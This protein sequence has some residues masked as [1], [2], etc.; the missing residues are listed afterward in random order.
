MAD[1]KEILIPVRI[2]S[3][4]FRDFAVFDAFERRG[5]LRRIA[6][7][8]GLLTLCA[9]ACLAL[10]AAMNTAKIP[11]LMLGWALLAIGWLLPA[12]YL[13][14]F[15]RGLRKKA[16]QMGLD[17]PRMVYTV[18]LGGQ[19]VLFQPANRAENAAQPPVHTPWAEVY[20]AWRTA[21]A[22]YLYV[23]PQKAYLL[24]N[25]QARGADDAGLWAFL[26]DHLAAEKLH[27]KMKK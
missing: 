4:A 20:A 25:G 14:R 27:D 12:F 22:V 8:T 11:G 21:R 9:C 5:T 19:G 15:F 2:D 24:P 6:L 16:R 23:A 1:E 18:R 26:S 7:F 3:K 13:G 10:G 17:Q